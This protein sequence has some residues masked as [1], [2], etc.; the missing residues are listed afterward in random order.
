MLERLAELA[1]SAH[2][3]DVL[4]NSARIVP[5]FGAHETNRTIA[6]PAAVPYLFSK[7]KISTGNAVAV[8]RLCA[9]E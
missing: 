9:G 6:R 1:D 3:I 8:E 4:V 2:Y 7:K 5:E